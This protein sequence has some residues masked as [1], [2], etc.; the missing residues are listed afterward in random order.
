[1][2]SITNIENN[3]LSNS[4][5]Q[6]KC[7]ICELDSKY[8]PVSKKISSKNILMVKGTIKNILKNKNEIIYRLYTI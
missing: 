8:P 5:Q 1:M 2:Y 7:I 4:I 6:K 3:K